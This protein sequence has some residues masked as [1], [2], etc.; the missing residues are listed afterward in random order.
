ML[1]DFHTHCFPDVLAERAISKLAAVSQT[2]PLT[3]GTA[4]D[5]IRKMDE[6]GVDRAVVCNIATN[7]HQQEKVNNFA[8]ELNSDPHFIS[9]GSVHPASDCIEV[10]LTRLKNA[11]I[12][13][14]K[15]HPDYMGYMIDD[16]AFEPILGK[17]TEL[18]LF[19]IIHA[20]YDVISPDLVHAPPE[21][22]RKVQDKFPDL[23]LVAA[24]FG[25][26]RMWD[27]V[28]EHL[29]GS[30]VYLDTS[31]C[32]S[33]GLDKVKAEKIIGEH[34]PDRILFGSDLPWSCPGE[35]RKYIDS[36]SL[37]EEIKNKIYFENALNLL[38]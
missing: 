16:P 15:L 10:E 25:A 23:T 29:A 36:L 28:L 31:L 20:G 26:C 3:C 4:S 17:C 7:P 6:C 1:I 14:V 8:I 24:H 19:V 13:G 33:F 5:L 35:T 18:G 37:T 12:K 11:G 30:S 9:L 27:E 2:E 21:K 22:I 38:K 34:D 32:Y